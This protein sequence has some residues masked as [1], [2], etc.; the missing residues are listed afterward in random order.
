MVRQVY[1]TTVLGYLKVRYYVLCIF[2]IFLPKNLHRW[3]C[4]CS[5]LEPICKQH[6]KVG[7]GEGNMAFLFLPGITFSRFSEAE[8]ILCHG[9]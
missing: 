8:L 5:F 6:S 4:S 3:H 2:D 1:E 9:M 7:W